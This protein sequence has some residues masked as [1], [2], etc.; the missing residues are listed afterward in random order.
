MEGE[1]RGETGRGAKERGGK[2]RERMGRGREWERSPE[3]IPSAKRRVI[4]LV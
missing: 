3:N 1:R 4:P 2:L